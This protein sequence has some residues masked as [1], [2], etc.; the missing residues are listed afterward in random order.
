MTHNGY[1]DLFV[2]KWR[3]ESHLFFN[4]GYGTFSEVSEARGN[5]KGRFWD[6]Q[7]LMYDFEPDGGL[8]VFVS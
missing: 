5:R 3:G 8:D 4:N 1:L 2:P 7:C 6:L